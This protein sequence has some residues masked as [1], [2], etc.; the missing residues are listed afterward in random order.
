[1]IISKM[2]DVYAVYYPIVLSFIWASGAFLSRWKDKSRARGLSDREK[3]SIVISAYNEEETIEE[4]LLSL[5]NLNYPA[6][7]IFVVD[8]KSSDRTLQKLHA[9]KKRFNNWEALTILEQKENKGKATA[10]NVALNQV[11]SKYMLVIDADSYLSADALDYLLAELVSV[12][13]SLNLRVT[14]V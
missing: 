4:V 8:D 9:F 10:L 5:R 12:M 11:T 7:E 1:M 13:L 14:I 3:I 6:L 2:V